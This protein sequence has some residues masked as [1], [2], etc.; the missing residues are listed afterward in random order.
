MLEFVAGHGPHHLLG[1]QPVDHREH[2]T[3]RGVCENRAV[4]T[5][6]D[7]ESYIRSQLEPWARRYLVEA[8][9]DVLSDERVTE[10]RARLDETTLGPAPWRG[11]VEPAN[12]RALGARPA[13]RQ[14]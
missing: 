6:D 4:V 1:A 10:L 11:I 2:A 8:E 9:P 5:A 3:R 12:R 7:V 13:S 14:P